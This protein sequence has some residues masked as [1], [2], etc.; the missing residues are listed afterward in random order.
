MI[1]MPMVCVCSVL[2]VKEWGV[3]PVPGDG[4]G[5]ALPFQLCVN[6]DARVLRSPPKRNTQWPTETS[7][8]V[9]RYNFAS[10]VASRKGGVL[11]GLELAAPGTEKA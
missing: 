10:D 6:Q 11:Q 7:R 2:C 1:H 8:L 5:Y 4:Y 3:V 9:I